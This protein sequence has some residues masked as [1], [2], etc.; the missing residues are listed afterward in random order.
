MNRYLVSA[1]LAASLLSLSSAGFACGGE[2]GGSP[3]DE[4]ALCG[5]DSGGTPKDESALCGG[6]SGGTP[7]DESAL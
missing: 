6:D 4:S 2:D 3:K 7:K 1:A 5:G